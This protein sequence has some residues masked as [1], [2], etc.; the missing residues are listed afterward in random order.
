MKKWMIIIGM[1]LVLA[2]VLPVAAAPAVQKASGG[3]WYLYFDGTRVTKSFTAQVDA[4]GN[5]KG[6]WIVTAAP[7]TEAFKADVTGLQVSGNRAIVEGV[8]TFAP[9]GSIVPV[10]AYVCMVAV[11]NGEGKGAVDQIS[12]SFPDRSEC[13]SP[14]VQLSDYYGNIQV[15]GG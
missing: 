12:N 7:K 13:E 6:E 5:A 4:E 8:V 2:L 10:G 3:G 11:D 1:M 14:T 9:K 15:S